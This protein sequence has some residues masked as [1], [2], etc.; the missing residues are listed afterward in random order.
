MAYRESKSTP[1]GGMYKLNSHLQVGD[2][3]IDRLSVLVLHTW[4]LWRIREL[5]VLCNCS[6]FICTSACTDFL[7][8]YRLKVLSVVFYPTGLLT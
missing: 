3:H 5:G 1:R 7:L 6:L 4:D 2:Q 8:I